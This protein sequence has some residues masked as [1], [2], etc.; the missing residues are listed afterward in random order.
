MQLLLVIALLSLT[1]ALLLPRSK[2][3]APSEV[4]QNKT[5]WEKKDS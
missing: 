4:M 5:I 2:Q 1:I 3:N